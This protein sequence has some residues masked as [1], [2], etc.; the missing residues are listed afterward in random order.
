MCTTSLRS[1]NPFARIKKRKKETKE[2]QCHKAMSYV[3]LSAV[4][5]QKVFWLQHLSVRVIL[6]TKSCAVCPGLYRDGEKVFWINHSLEWQS[7]IYFSAVNCNPCAP[8]CTSPVLPFVQVET[9]FVRN[10]VWL[11][12]FLARIAI[13]WNFKGVWK[14]FSLTNVDARLNS[15]FHFVFFLETSLPPFLFTPLVLILG[16]PLEPYLFHFCL[17]SQ[18]ENEGTPSEKWGTQFDSLKI[19]GLCSIKAQWCSLWSGWLCVCL[20]IYLSIHLFY[21]QSFAS[22]RA[23]QTWQRRR[24][25][26]SNVFASRRRRVPLWVIIW[27]S[28]AP[29]FWREQ[30]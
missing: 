28:V 17:S 23:A 27:M 8:T 6:N 14:L 4:R 1:K 29:L 21:R 25:I 11:F 13:V 3:C 30:I 24:I 20:F 12:F 7:M 15:V 9:Q 2:S 26:E 10:F 18:G 22:K 19:I 5:M 16:V